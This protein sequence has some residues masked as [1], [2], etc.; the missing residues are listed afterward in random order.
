MNLCFRVNCMSELLLLFIVLVTVSCSPAVYPTATC[1][2][3]R[4]NPSSEPESAEKS[5]DK[6]HDGHPAH[7]SE[8]V[9]HHPVAGHPDVQEIVVHRVPI[10]SEHRV[11]NRY[12]TS[13]ESNSHFEELPLMSE[14]QPFHHGFDEME[15]GYATE[16]PIDDVEDEETAGSEPQVDSLMLPTNDEE[17]KDKLI[18]VLTFSGAPAFNIIKKYAVNPAPDAV[19]HITRQSIQQNPSLTVRQKGYLSRVLDDYYKFILTQVKSLRR[20]KK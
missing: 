2:I 9:A 10:S 7:Q 16:A 11:P 17:E 14:D 3:A 20:K 18:P 4:I 5:E 13:I 1:I 15:S 6:S 8:P 12:E 19:P